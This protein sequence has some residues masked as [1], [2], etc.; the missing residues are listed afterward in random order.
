MNDKK[1]VKGD[2]SFKIYFNSLFISNTPWSKRLKLIRKIW[3]TKISEENI[4]YLSIEIDGINKY[5]Y[6]YNQ[7]TNRSDYS[8]DIKNIV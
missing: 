1:K 2:F 6:K 7:Y 4:L 8:S 3:K 5:L